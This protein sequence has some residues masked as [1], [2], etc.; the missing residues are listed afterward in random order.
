M[1][2]GLQS[3]EDPY[4]ERAEW[5]VNEESTPASKTCHWSCVVLGDPLCSVFYGLFISAKVTYVY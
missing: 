3:T 2:C 5:Q 1:G 4:S